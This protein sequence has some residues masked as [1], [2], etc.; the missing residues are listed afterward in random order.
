M[1]SNHLI[2]MIARQLYNS[3]A[4]SDSSEY[5]IEEKLVT[6]VW[7]HDRVKDGACFEDLR[8]RFVQRFN[9]SAPTRDTMR[10]WEKK[11]FSTGSVLD[12]KRTGR[13]SSRQ[14]HIESVKATCLKYPMK[15]S[16]QI[17][18]ELG[19]PR[20]TVRKIMKID[21]GLKRKKPAST[22]HEEE[23][24]QT[25]AEKTPTLCAEWRDAYRQQIPVSNQLRDFSSAVYLNNS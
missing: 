25:I 14:H 13:P 18:L 6:C 8:K 1:F 22:N 12:L 2:L 5:T 7:V 20:S 10:A 11:A 23:G 4:E 15:S 24:V 9:K 19:I 17:A 21:L 3:M 16:R